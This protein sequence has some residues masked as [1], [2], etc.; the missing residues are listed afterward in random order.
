MGNWYKL[1]Y[2]LIWGCFQ[3]LTLVKHGT[4]TIPSLLPIIC[5]H[6][7]KNNVSFPRVG[8]S[9]VFG[10]QSHFFPP[11]L[12]PPF[13]FSFQFMETYHSLCCITVFKPK[14][15]KA[16]AGLNPPKKFA[17]LTKRFDA[18]IFIL[19]I[20]CSFWDLQKTKEREPDVFVISGVI[21][22]FFT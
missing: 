6:K 12:L 5:F 13:F 20:I 11:S 7:P 9:S 19:A 10:L 16:K 21:W 22:L 8:R 15:Q 2:T 14:K 3:R 4:R 18:T 17:L 1:L